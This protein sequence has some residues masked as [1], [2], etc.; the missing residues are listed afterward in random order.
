MKIRRFHTCFALTLLLILLLP[1]SLCAFDFGL[2]TNQYAGYGYE[3]GDD[4]VFE[5]KANFLPRL[6]FL[7]GENGSFLV[8][9]GFTVGTEDKTYYFPELLNTEFNIRLGGSLRGGAVKA[10]RIYYADPLSFIASGLFDGA[11]FSYNSAAGIFRVGAWYTGLLYKETAN[12][13]M[14]A[15]DLAIYESEL[16][17]DDFAKTYFAPKRLLAS[18]DWE[19]PSILEM[20][21]LKAAVTSQ[22]ELTEADEKLHSQYFTAKASVPVKR[23]LFDFGGSLQTAQNTTQEETHLFVAFA[24]DFGVFW[25]IPASFH[26]RLSFQ[27]HFAGG[28]VDDSVGAFVPVTNR[29]FAMVYQPKLSALTILDFTYTARIN[30]AVGASF[31]ALCFI[32]NDLGTFKNYPVKEDSEGYIL[33]TEFFARVVWS[34]FSDLQ[35]ILA[36]GT[37]FPSLGNVSDEKPQ[38][39][40]GLSAILSIF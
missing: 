37:F 21:S 28:K 27:G 18:V 38:W 2:I 40:I 34:P 11:Q 31:S 22:T 14:T 4:N 39:R 7:I 8:S 13:T 25:T 23:F 29:T 1:V 32:R 5:Y 36:G 15:N 16:D 33:G 30:R 26:S 10:G 3:G 24:W 6:S 17:Y 20:F 9:A 19:H 12:I 35:F